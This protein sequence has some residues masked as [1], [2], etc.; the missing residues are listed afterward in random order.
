MRWRIPRPVGKHS[1]ALVAVLGLT[2]LVTLLAISATAANGQQIDDLAEASRIYVEQRGQAYAGA[3]EETESPDD[4]GLWCSKVV[5]R[6]DTRAVVNFGPTFSEFVVTVTFERIDGLWQVVAETQEPAPNWQTPVCLQSGGFVEDGQIGTFGLEPGDARGVLG[7]RFP[8]HESGGELACERLV[9]D[10]GAA[11]GG[12]A[13]S[14]GEVSAELLRDQGVVRIHLGEFNRTDLVDSTHDADLGGAWIDSANLV[15][16]QDGQA[17]IDVHLSSAALA[18]VTV[19]DSPA[20]LVIDAQPGGAPVPAPAAK[21]GNIVVLQPRAAEAHSYPL[22]IRGYA[23]TFEANVLARIYVD[24]QVQAESFTTAASWLEAWGEFELILEHGPTGSVE[25][26]VG[27][28]SA[29]DG[30]EQ[31]VRIPIVME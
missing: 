7:F 21:A 29:A 22:T 28:E 13:Q 23:R 4:S 5:E 27:E 10:L 25:L 3:C 18:S 2:M 19:L 15:W 31:G 8:G 30:S 1:G 9:V 16:S 20:R 24:G 6:S 26:F 11:D 17:Y 12:P 14:V